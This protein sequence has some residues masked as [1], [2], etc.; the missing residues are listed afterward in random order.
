MGVIAPAETGLK[1][2]WNISMAGSI[3]VKTARITN[4]NSSAHKYRHFGRK[5][6][7]AALTTLFPGQLGRCSR[8]VTYIIYPPVVPPEPG[9]NDHQAERTGYGRTPAIGWT[10]HD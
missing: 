2:N 1:S 6:S 3:I 4:T 7:L 9:R 10:T 5:I 8:V